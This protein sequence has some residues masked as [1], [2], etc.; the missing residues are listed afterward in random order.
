MNA[1]S[2]V[3]VSLSLGRKLTVLTMVTTTVTLTVVAV[4]GIVYDYRS[5][6][7]TAL[8]ESRTL[9]QVAAATTAPAVTFGDEQAAAAALAGVG[10]GGGAHSAAVLDQAG[11]VVGW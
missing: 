6:Q 11:T 1:L 10:R 7:D 5:G 3:F 2:R 9:A 4:V 8:R